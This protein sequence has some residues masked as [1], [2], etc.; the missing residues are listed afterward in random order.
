[1]NKNAKKIYTQINDNDLHKYT[2]LILW[3]PLFIM[4]E[5]A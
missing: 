2:C 4:K 1:M 5:I 3:T